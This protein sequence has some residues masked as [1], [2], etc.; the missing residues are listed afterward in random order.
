MRDQHQLLTLDPLIITLNLILE[1][2]LHIVLD[3]RLYYMINQI[4][5]ILDQVVIMLL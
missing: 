2:D 1:V 3:Q 5:L 4:M